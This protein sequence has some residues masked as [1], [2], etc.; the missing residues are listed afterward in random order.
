MYTLNIARAIKKMTVNKVRDFIFETYY[1]RI[2][3]SKE[4][5]FY[6]LK[7][8]KK[9]IIVACKQI[10]RKKIPDAREH[11]QSFFRKKNRKS[12]K[13]SEII[14]YH[15]KTFGNPNIVDIKSIIAEHTKTTLKL[16]KTIRQ[17][18][19]VSCNTSLYSD[20]KKVNIF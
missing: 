7:H 9:I 11:Y 20:T 4:N 18:E 1:K 6:S 2:G 13:Q 5:S 3:F 17:G 15:P 16:S 12:V 19:K 10:N 8:L 14:T